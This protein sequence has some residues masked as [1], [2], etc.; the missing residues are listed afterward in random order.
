MFRYTT[1]NGRTKRVAVNINDIFTARLENPPPRWVDLPYYTEFQNTG[2]THHTLGKMRN[3][4]E[5]NRA[6]TTYIQVNGLEDTVT[7]RKRLGQRNGLI[8][9]ME[10]EVINEVIRESEASAMEFPTRRFGIELEILHE[11]NAS[12]VAEMIRE[13][14][15]ECHDEY[16]NHRSR[17]HWKIV[18]DA[19]VYGRNMNGMEVVSPPLSGQAGIDEV[20][21]MGRILVAIGAKVNGRCGYHCHIEADELTTRELR[22][23]VANF[24]RRERIV[25]TL[26]PPSR[27][28]N[29]YCRSITRI[30]YNEDTNE[31][32]LIESIR[33]RRARN[34]LIQDA[35]PYGCRYYKMNLRSL[36]RH[37]TIEFR[38]HSGT[39]NPSKIVNHVMFCLAFVE[40]YKDVDNYDAVGHESDIRGATRTM[41]TEMATVLPEA[42]QNNFV[43]FYTRR[44]QQLAPAA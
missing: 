41:L 6:V 16:Y 28:S 19:S 9:T 7:L 22:N 36:A 15:I 14:G 25:E 26:V 20:R 37:G 39:C 3:A 27:L 10:T 18:S 17:E 40:Y 42:T 13:R 8:N 21:K 12:E 33:S 2:L 38:Y 35:N 34:T 24:V 5:Y 4:P 11:N 23:V 32:Y 43:N 30:G 29:S 1:E 31:E 44:Q